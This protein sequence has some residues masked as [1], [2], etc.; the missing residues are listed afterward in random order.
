MLNKIPRPS[1]GLA[2][3]LIVLFA[4]GS[5]RLSAQNPSNEF[6][7][8]VGGGLPVMF[9]NNAPLTGFAGD[10]G[11]G[12]MTFV[13]RQ[14]GI[15]VGMELGFSTVNINVDTLRTVTRGL[16]D[17]HGHLF[18]MHTT[19]RN[20]A[21]NQRTISF[22][23]P[24]MLQFSPGFEDRRHSFYAMGGTKII[25]RYRTDYESEVGSLNNLAYYPEFGNW[26][27]T[28]QFANLGTFDG[29][30]VSGGFNLGLSA[31]LALETG[32][33]WRI[34]RN[35]ILY[36]GVFLD[37]ILGNPAKNQRKPL[38]DYI[39]PQQLD[40]LTLLNFADRI[41]FVTTGI[42][43]RLAFSRFPRSRH[44]MIPCP[45]FGRFR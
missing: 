41:D 33:K 14:I 6:S 8:S 21:E 22:S 12:F 9:S 23:I 30:A 17:Y 26:S 7:I 18:D 37:Y 42:K 34:G 45:T 1:S 19:L 29:N 5:L 32:M 27:G 3:S 24:L 36:T 43:L 10:V 39:L 4:I 11:V 20:Y 2:Y 31:V 44:E 15:H 28:Q 25:L 38:G 35:T 40:N 13:S 16:R